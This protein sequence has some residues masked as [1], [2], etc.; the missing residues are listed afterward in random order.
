MCTTDSSI[1][2]AG[3]AWLF[4]MAWRDLRS[5]VGKLFLFMSSIII[6]IA[7][8]VAIQS[9]GNN[10]TDSI[11]YQS[12]ALMGADFIIDSSNPP[13]D[14]VIGIM[15]SLGGANSREINFASMV[16]FPQKNGSKLVQVL[17]VDGDFPY[18][19]EFET[20]PSSAAR[21]YQKNNGALVDATVMLQFDLKP[22]DSIKVGNIVLP[23]EGTL[24]SVPGRS[25]LTSSVA[26][27]VYIPYSQLETTGLLQKGSRVEYKYYFV[28]N[29]GQDL[30]VLYEEVD[31]RLDAEGADLDTHLD[32]SRRLG[33]RYNNFGKFLNIVAFI[34]LLLGCVGIASA[35]HVYIRG[36]LRSIAVLKCMGASRGQTFKIFL[37]QIA[38]LGGLGGLIGTILGVSLQMAAPGLLRE[39][40]PVDVLVTISYPA[41]ALGLSL[42]V[43]MSV[44]FALLPLLRTWYVSPLSVLRVQE[45][46]DPKTGKARILILGIIFLFLFIFAQRIL[47]NWRY[48]LSFIVGLLVTFSL[49]YGV[50]KVL[51]WAIKRYFPTNWG[52]CSRQSLLNLFRPQNQTATLLLSIGVGAFLI[53]TLYFSKDIL[54]SKVAI[55]DNESSPNIILLDVQTDQ[56]NDVKN[57]I[58][59]NDI[60]VLDNIPIITM[61]VQ[62]INGRN[63]N[64]IRNDT[65]S[66]IGRWVL[67]HEFRVTYRDSLIA[68]ETIK[69]G[70]W[71]AKADPNTVVPISVAQNFAFDAKVGVG[72]R[73][74]FN[75]QGV[76]IETTIGS[77]R[78]V[79]W[80]RV[81]LNFSVLF[82]SGI[83]EDAPKFH[84]LTTRTPSNEVSAQ[85]QRQ[86]VSN[87]PN[88][89]I[90]DLRQILELLEGILEKISLVINFMALLSILTGI[91][92]LIGAVRTSKYQRIKESVLLRTLGAQNAQLLRISLY[93]YAFLGVLGS[94][95]GI[96]LSLFGSFLLARFVFEEPFVPS[97][98]PFILLL[99]ILTLLV[100][101]IGLLNS[102]SVLRSPP[103]EILRSTG[104]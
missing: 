10:L 67:N 54:L 88:I 80:G 46:S 71:V 65:T 87:F 70:A 97:T 63:V 93:E 62:E 13:N 57:T 66:N 81:Q 26:P 37:I 104:R 11:A 53:S 3:P 72:D 15:D 42:G 7:A 83:L 24:T 64:D 100:V 36:K 25:A 49:L 78:E 86:L 31:P 90:I 61:R 48:A 39:Y 41:I 82:P 95:T 84:V 73:V 52:F 60:P 101:G 12:K 23:I 96:L 9:F 56:V 2:K 98:E 19:G 55:G 20:T 27:A 77:I 99:P 40:L 69:E 75:V 1:K 21:N 38:G 45:E 22:G 30:E 50:A 18:Y 4:K 35:V 6:G 8:V 34:A 16:A 51:M 44:A 43:L 89:S 47:N 68:S 91:I 76:L 28:A 103:L 79:D 29:P 33:R 92:V 85:L 94:L 59:P 14:I 102:R 5:N 58:L 32:E 74:T 17:G